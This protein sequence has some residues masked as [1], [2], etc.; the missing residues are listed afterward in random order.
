MIDL[1]EVQSCVL[2][3]PGA[4]EVEVVFLRFC[5]RERTRAFLRVAAA[6][7]TSAAAG[8]QRRAAGDHRAV[9]V[10]L[11][12]AGLRL[13]GVSDRAHEALGGAFTRGMRRAADRLLDVG[14]SAPEHWAPP[15]DDGSAPVHA[16]V[17]RYD[18]ADLGALDEVLDS[19]EHCRHGGGAAGGQVAARVGSWRG[20]VRA[21]RTEPFGFVDGISD[22]VVEGAPQPLTPGNGVWDEQAGDWRRVRTGELVLGHADES[23]AVAGHLGA[24]QL[25]RDGSYLVLRKLEQDVRGFHEASQEWAEELGSTRDEV[26]AQLVGRRHDGTPLGLEQPERPPHEREPRTNDFLF[27]DDRR[28]RSS[29]PPSSHVRRSNPRDGATA[30]KA[31]A[32][33]HLL[34]RRSYPYEEPAGSGAGEP[35]RG[36]LFMA[37]CADVRRQ[38]E[39]V[40]AQ[41]LQDGNRFGLGHERDPLLGQRP[42]PDDDRTPAVEARRRGEGLVSIAHAQRR[43]RRALSTFVTVRG[44]EY[45]FLPS[46]SALRLVGDPRRP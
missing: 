8:E 42:D 31:T 33:R 17:L 22:P 16:A 21:D 44:G 1:T 6:H 11:S 46:R 10:A 30:A 20:R 28:P 26:E 2:R 7:V 34:F 35:R 18:S 13:A 29:M 24:A 9:N 45:L 32:R 3:P 25:E 39:F 43:V 12:A 19:P 27:A 38:F 23:G 40:Q 37:C 14:P 41:W 15:F 4:T 5:C 36:L